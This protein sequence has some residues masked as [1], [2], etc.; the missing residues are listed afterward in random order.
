M[1]ST[2]SSNPS[3]NSATGA[4]EQRIRR[5]NL[6]SV[7]RGPLTFADMP[8]QRTLSDSERT[9]PVGTSCA[10]LLQLHS[11]RR[12]KRKLS[13]GGARRTNAAARPPT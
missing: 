8:G 4:P 1:E 9:V 7:S 11:P 13:G 2:Q 10:D 12:A 6:F 3:E 5:L